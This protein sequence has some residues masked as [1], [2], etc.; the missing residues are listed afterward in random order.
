MVSI[1]ISKKARI[2]PVSYRAFKK[3]HRIWIRSNTML[4]FGLGPT[5][6]Q[7]LE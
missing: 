6:T 5:Q 4:K 2:S 7:K 1:I 3:G